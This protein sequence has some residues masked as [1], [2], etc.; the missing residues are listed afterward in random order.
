MTKQL[1]QG[2]CFHAHHDILCE[3]CYDY[4]GRVD[5]INR[6]KPANERELRLRLFKITQGKLPKDL[7]EVCQKCED[8][9]QEHSK[10]WRKYAKACNEACQE[11]VYRGAWQ[12]RDEAWQKYEESCQKRDEAIHKHKEVIGALHEKECPDCPWDGKTIFGAKDD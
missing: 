3:F 6:Y 12:E 11:P 7:I 8:A 9:R 5:Y 2:M 1:I 4:Q 10:A